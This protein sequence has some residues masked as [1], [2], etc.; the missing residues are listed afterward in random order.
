MVKQTKISETRHSEL[1]KK[2]KSL[3]VS[4]L[5]L[6]LFSCNFVLSQNLKYQDIKYLLEHEIEDADNYISQKGFLFHR[7]EESSN[8][9][10]KT[11]FW[12]FERNISNN[13]SVA[14]ISKY[15]F[16]ANSGSISYQLGD[17]K[18]FDGIKSYCKS[19]DF[20]HTTTETDKEGS[21]CT[22]YESVKYKIQFCSGLNN[23]TNKNVYIIRLSHKPK[24]QKVITGNKIEANQKCIIKGTLKKELFYGP[25]NFGE[26]TLI[27]K[28][29]YSFIL[30]LEKP[31]LLLDSE[32]G[33]GKWETVTKIHVFDS[34]DSI[35]LSFFINEKVK[36]TCSLAASHTAYHN[37]P[38]ITWDLFDIKLASATHSAK[39]ERV[40]VNAKVGDKANPTRYN[41]IIPPPPD[42][43]PRDFCEFTLNMLISK[44]NLQHKSADIWYG[45][46]QFLTGIIT[47]VDKNLKS[48]NIRVV[49][50]GEKL[51]SEFRSI[52]GEDWTVYLDQKNWS[53]DN[54]MGHSCSMNLPLL[55]VPG[56][57]L[58]LAMTEGYPDCGTA[59]NGVWFLTYAK[60]LEGNSF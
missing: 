42:D 59:M 18:T 34:N 35:D 9:D 3:K 13:L 15:C 30:V 53:N 17:R 5:L 47:A 29:N 12:S 39:S 60:A 57:R 27:D 33:S 1:P 38:A 2:R 31:I 43:K 40:I 52:D 14:F 20:K 45:E 54:E 51:K 48:I 16:V 25:P 11:M 44:E 8:G 10:C 46:Y 49:K 23:G 28:K 19:S 21:L 50:T 55:L 32:L 36:I 56:R 4:L 41:E 58:K 22:T 6:T 26:D 24:P 37:A 7:T